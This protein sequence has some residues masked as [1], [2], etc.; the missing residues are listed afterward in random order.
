[1]DIVELDSIAGSIVG[2]P[3]MYGLSGEQFKRLTIAV[4]LVANPAIIFLGAHP[5]MIHSFGEVYASLVPWRS[6]HAREG[7]CACG[8]GVGRVS[9]HAESGAARVQTSPRAAWMR[10]RRRS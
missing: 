1:M 2:M 4:E 3:G 10:A 8:G 7:L 5:V 6:D 9:K